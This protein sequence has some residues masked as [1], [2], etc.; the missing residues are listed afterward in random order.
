[1]N[2][3]KKSSRTDLQV[4]STK[5]NQETEPQYYGKSHKKSKR[6]KSKTIL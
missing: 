6:Q 3:K 2:L 5:K 4:S 1:M